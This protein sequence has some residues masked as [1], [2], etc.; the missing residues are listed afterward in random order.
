ML[1][2]NTKGNIVI[3]KMQRT[4]QNFRQMLIEGIGRMVEGVKTTLKRSKIGYFGAGGAEIFWD[5]EP[6]FG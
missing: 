4:M 2:P 5:F 3:E 6:N 1:G